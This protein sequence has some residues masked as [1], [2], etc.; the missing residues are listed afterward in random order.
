VDGSATIVNKDYRFTVF[1][2]DL[3]PYGPIGKE[4]LDVIRMTY[5]FSCY[6]ETD[7]VVQE[8]QFPTIAVAPS[9]TPVNQNWRTDYRPDCPPPAATEIPPD[10]YPLKVVSEAIADAGKSIQVKVN[11]GTPGLTYVLGFVTVGGTTLRRKQVDTLIW[12][13]QPLNPMMIGPGDL[14]PDVVPPVI[15]SDSTA[16][17]MGFDG[18][19]ILQN[20]TTSNIVITLPPNPILGQMVE[21]IDAYGTDGTYPVTFRGDGDVPI[22]GDG[23]LVFVSSINYDCLRWKWT[24]AN[25]HL[26]ATRFDFLG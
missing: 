10:T 2:D 20:A 22:D 14:N 15:I 26:M 6:L 16:L 25:W 7:E 12:I 13:D 1:P 21:F 8:V 23:R 17:P 24:G 18:V 4:N 19:V 5:D 3:T 9:T 11:A